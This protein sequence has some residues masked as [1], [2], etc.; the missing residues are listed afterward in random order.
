METTNGLYLRREQLVKILPVSLRTISYWQ[1]RKVLP[2]Y[3]VGRAVLF[4]RADV[5]AA[6][7]RFRISAVGEMR[8]K[9]GAK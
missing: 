9:R 5:E 3:R 7:E 2:F 8:P 4:K 1:A 6:L